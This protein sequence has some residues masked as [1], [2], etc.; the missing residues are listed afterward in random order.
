MDWERRK[1]KE[2]CNE[3]GSYWVDVGKPKDTTVVHA[4][5]CVDCGKDFR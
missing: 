1:C 2:P 4:I 5:I 3:C